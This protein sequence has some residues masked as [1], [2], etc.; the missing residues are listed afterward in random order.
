[1]TALRIAITGSPG[2]GKSTICAA[3]EAAGW[4]VQTVS[5]LADEHDCAEPFDTDDDA[6]P[7]DVARLAS[8]LGDIWAAP[9]LDEAAVTIDGRSPILIDGH[10]SHL[11][12]TYAVC[13][14]RCRPDVLE[15][16]LRVR[17]YPEWKVEA[18]VDWE[19]IGSA[20]SDEVGGE[21]DERPAIDI[22]ATS[23]DAAVGFATLVAWLTA[24]MPTTA[25]SDA[26]DWISRAED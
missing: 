2:V 20:W 8:A 9:L 24:G 18:N 23:A 4:S 25:P 22:D 1:M 5:A 26:I 15:A 14:I 12:P 11:L 6:R 19:W 10:M 16:R 21:S 7:I 3:A 17:D 13:V